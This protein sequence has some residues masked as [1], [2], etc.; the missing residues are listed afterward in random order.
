VGGLLSAFAQ[1]GGGNMVLALSR[2][3][4]VPSANLEMLEPL[5]L[6]VHPPPQPSKTFATGFSLNG[7]VTDKLMWKIKI[8]YKSFDC[9]GYTSQKH[10][11]PILHKKE[12]LGTLYTHWIH[13][14]FIQILQRRIKEIIEY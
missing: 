5:G 7:I 11:F 3:L 13:F 10:S 6:S 14:K 9:I 8:G 1:T 4:Q 12:L 2:C